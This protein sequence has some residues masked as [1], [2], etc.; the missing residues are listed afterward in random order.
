MGILDLLQTAAA[1]VLAAPIAMLGVAYL[2]DGRLLGGA[3]VVVAILLV[4]VQRI[5]LTPEDLSLGLAS[6][7]TEQVVLDPTDADHEEN[8][9]NEDE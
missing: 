7:V 4:V 8:G 3:F 2:L 9:T 5:L 6:E 1:V